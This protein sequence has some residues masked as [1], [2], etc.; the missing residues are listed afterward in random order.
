M[1][2]TLASE[3]PW[4]LSRQAD[5]AEIRNLGRERER[6]REHFLAEN[7]RGET[8]KIQWERENEFCK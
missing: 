6:E 2:A 1:A 4:S 3:V 7:Q 5:E 8:L